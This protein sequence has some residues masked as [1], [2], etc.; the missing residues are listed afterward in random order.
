VVATDLGKA[1]LMS[2]TMA[3]AD[4]GGV[5]VLEAGGEFAYQEVMARLAAHSEATLVDP[6]LSLEGLYHV[7]Q[8]T[9]VTKILVSPKAPQKQL[10]AAVGSTSLTRPLELRA[11]SEVH[12][13]LFVPLT[14]T[15]EMLGTSLNGVSKRLSLLAPLSPMPL[16]H[17]AGTSAPSGS[18]QHRWRRSRS[19]S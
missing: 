19:P 14:G 4:G 7:I 15:I 8:L 2:Q 16:M 12:D 11:S 10:K 17:F 6:F 9:E 1:F 5:L 18:E 3:G 13:R